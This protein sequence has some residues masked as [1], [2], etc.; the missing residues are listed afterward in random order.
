ME[1]LRQTIEAAW[2]N[3]ELMQT[4]ETQEAIR[5][6]IELLDKGTLRCAQPTEDGWQVNDWV[7]KAVILYFPIQKM[8]TIE[9]PPFEYHDKMKLK[10]DYASQGV[11]VVPP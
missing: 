5:E 1:A 4:N 9:L 8:A 6:V 7:K 2:E 11:R 10:T 3:R